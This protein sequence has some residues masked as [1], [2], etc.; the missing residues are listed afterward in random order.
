MTWHFLPWRT[1]RGGHSRPPSHRMLSRTFFRKQSQRNSSFRAF[2]LKRRAFHFPLS[3]ISDRQPD[4]S[5]RTND[6]VN[7]MKEDLCKDDSR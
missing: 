4:D 6:V 7:P 2:C 3:A 5:D 1:Y